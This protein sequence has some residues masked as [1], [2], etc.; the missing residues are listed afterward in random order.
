MTLPG[1]QLDFI[2]KLM[3][4]SI[5]V[6]TIVKDCGGSCEYPNPN[7]Y[8]HL[9][10]ILTQHA[11]CQGYGIDVQVVRM[12]KKYTL[13]SNEHHESPVMITIVLFFE[14]A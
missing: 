2:N 3:K 1:D 6:N 5:N 11:A 13:N 12:K 8:K 14:N 4:T 10:L 7:S 9:S